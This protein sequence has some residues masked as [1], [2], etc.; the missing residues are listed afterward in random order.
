MKNGRKKYRNTFK[1][2]RECGGSLTIIRLYVTKTFII[3]ATEE[4]SRV[5]L[6]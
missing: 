1:D 3:I 6:T 5:T 2:M 4:E